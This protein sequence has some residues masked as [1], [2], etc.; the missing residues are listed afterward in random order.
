MLSFITE[1]SNTTIMKNTKDNI[2]KRIYSQPVIELILLD[3]E[4]SLALESIPPYGPD[5]SKNNLS[6]EHFNTD[7]YATNRA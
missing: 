2:S 5:E 3:N 1:K 7:P 6:P 4:I